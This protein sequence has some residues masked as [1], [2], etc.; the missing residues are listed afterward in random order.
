MRRGTAAGSTV[1]PAVRPRISEPLSRRSTGRAAAIVCCAAALAAA[2]ACV[3]PDAA[4]SELLV[5][6]ASDLARAMPAIAAAFEEETGVRVTVTLGSSGQLAQQVLQGAPID[7]FLSADQHWVERLAE[8]GR[9]APGGRTVYARG[10][11]AL[12]TAAHRERRFESLEE[13]AGAGLRR[14]AIAN[15]EHAPYGRAAREALQTLG[16]WELLG[17]R[18][19][20][21]EN[22]R[23]T[24]QFVGTGN[25]DAALSALPLMADDDGH[26]VAVPEEL[27]A[28]LVQEGAVIEGRPLAPTAAEFLGFLAGPRGREILARHR[29]ILPETPD[30]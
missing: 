25:V 27:H 11:L 26:W 19:V 24:L 5:A 29:F 13:L 30:P 16:L 22:V 28:P 21:A 20:I 2:S 8:A 1:K 15:P 18:L 12:V 14:V 6:A 3:R 10:L 7:V 17:D 4:R 9:T 23:Q